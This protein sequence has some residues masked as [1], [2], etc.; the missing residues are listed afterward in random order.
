[1]LNRD[2]MNRDV[3][4]RGTV[5]RDEAKRGKNGFSAPRVAWSYTAVSCLA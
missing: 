2:M 3:V 1:M 5:M 4:K